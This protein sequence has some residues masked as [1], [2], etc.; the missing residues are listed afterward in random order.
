MTFLLDATSENTPAHSTTASMDTIGL[1][2][3]GAFAVSLI[4]AVVVRAQDFNDP[5]H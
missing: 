3:V 1:A 5:H 2:L 4:A